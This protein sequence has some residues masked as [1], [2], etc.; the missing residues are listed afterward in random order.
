M[1]N[2][3][4]QGNNKQQIFKQKFERFDRFVVTT[5]IVLT[6]QDSLHLIRSKSKVLVLRRIFYKVSYVQ[7]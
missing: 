6:V 2:P 4:L 5:T 7:C 3:F 1:N